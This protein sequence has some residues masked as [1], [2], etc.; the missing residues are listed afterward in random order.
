[1]SIDRSQDGI[2]LCQS[3]DL[4]FGSDGDAPRA[5]GRS[6]RIGITRAA[7]ALLRFYVRDSQFVSGA[8]T[9]NR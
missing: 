1:L 6:T 2:D 8:R 4:W 3:E 5:I 7:D 9:L